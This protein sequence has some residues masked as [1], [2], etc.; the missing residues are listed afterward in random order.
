M[1]TAI[2]YI[3]I[4]IM[5]AYFGSF[6]T[7]AVYRI[8]LELDITHE[9]SFCPNCKHKLGFLDL[10][11]VFSYIFLG[12]KCRYCGMKIKPRYCIL[13]VLSGLT[14]VAFTYSLNINLYNIETEKLILLGFSAL[15]FA[16]LFIIAG[17]DKERIQVQKK[18]LL[19]TITVVAVYMSYMYIT[20]N[21]DIIR[22]VGYLGF[23]LFLV[24]LDT[25][26]I[27]KKGEESYALNLWMLALVMCMFTGEAVFLLTAIYTLL[28]CALYVLIKKIKNRKKYVKKEKEKIKLPIAFYMCVC[29]VITYIICNFFVNYTLL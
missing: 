22:Y 28:A 9:H 8:P 2:L 4:F 1:V 11:P 3:L 6:Y 20:M 23:V 17:I 21:L 7:L 16:G 18:V 27:R 24:I 14:F 26:K 12:G 13:E 25:I 10:F 5:G 19:Y 15:Y 29:N